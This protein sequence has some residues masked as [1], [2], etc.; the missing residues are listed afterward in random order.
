MDVRSDTRT[1]HTEV[2]VPNPERVLLP[3][4]YAEADLQLDRKDNIPSVPIQAVS[5]RGDRTS[6]F[7]VSPDGTI[8]Q[9]PVEIGLETSSD[10]EVV[11]GL[12]EGEEVVVSDRGGLKPGEKVIPKEMSV[13]EYKE[14]DAQ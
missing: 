13:F 12:K 1:M 11:S 5:H 4:L 7:V 6:V 9:R 10:A 8:E 3:G 2:D 14:G